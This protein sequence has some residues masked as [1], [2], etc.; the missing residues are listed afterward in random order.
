MTTRKLTEYLDA[1]QD[2]ESDS[3]GYHSAE[4]DNLRKGIGSVKRQRTNDES[5]GSDV[6]DIEDEEDNAT[7]DENT[8][9]RT[10][11]SRLLD[12][13]END[14]STRPEKLPGIPKP[15]SKKNLVATNAAI[16][17]SGVVYLSRLPPFMKPSKL[18]S[19]LAPYGTIN[20]IFLSPED[21]TSH[22]RRVRAGGN[23][24]RSFTD[25]WVEFVR[26][27]DA[28]RACELLN[29]HAIGGKKGTF[30]RDDIWN[31]LYLKG[32]KW[33]NLT[34]QIAAENA[35]KAARMTA[36]VARVGRENRE[37]VSNVER[38]KMLDGMEKK[39]RLRDENGG[40][41]SDDTADVNH[42]DSVTKVSQKAKRLKGER[43]RH[44]TQLAPA[45]KKRSSEQSEDVKRVLSKIF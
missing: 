19:L 34:E 16:K 6:D 44:F 30:Y 24:K 20:R 42:G 17:A 36:E 43:P 38:A 27:V 5:D 10:K 3:Q 1:D 21:P 25:G 33:R 37:F 13:Q 35:E 28:K 9:T 41:V 23:K 29:G 40:P 12:S 32:F 2:A 39:K 8:A 31:L 7:Q 11:G 4:E 18:R 22:A 14:Q 26:K 45:P 15:I